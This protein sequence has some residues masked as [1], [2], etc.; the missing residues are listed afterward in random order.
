MSKSIPDA[1][2][3]TCPICGQMVVVHGPSLLELPDGYFDN[4]KLREHMIGPECIAYG[5]LNE[6]KRLVEAVRGTRP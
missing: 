5:D 1:K 6:A 2:Q 3:W 4:C